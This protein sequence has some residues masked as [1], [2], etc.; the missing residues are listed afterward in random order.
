MASAAP[1]FEVSRL[2]A[3]ENFLVLVGGE[4]AAV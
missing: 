1:V 4:A 3:L 2:Q